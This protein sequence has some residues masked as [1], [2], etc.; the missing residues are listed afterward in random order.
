MNTKGIPVGYQLH[1]T[2]WENDGDNYKT[3]I[4]SGLSKEDTEFLVF[5]ASEF[6]WNQTTKLVEGNDGNSMIGLRNL[7]LEAIKRYPN[8][9]DTYRIK[10]LP[11]EEAIELFDEYARF[12]YNDSRKKDPK[13]TDSVLDRGEEFYELMMDL[14]TSL[15]A[16]P[17]EAYWNI[18][19]FVRYCDKIKVYY[20]PGEIEDVTNQFVN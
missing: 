12:S 2:S 5:I 10:N 16:N 14:I 6:G 17:D 3:E 1:V 20:V 7:Y 11:S 4:I 8:V 13:Y 18:T 15:L 9:S 19:G